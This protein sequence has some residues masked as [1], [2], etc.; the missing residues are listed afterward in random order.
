MC[1]LG[2][3]LLRRSW[4]NGYATE[5]SRALLEHVF[6]TVGQSRVIAQAIEGNAASR[7]V[8]ERLGMRYVRTFRSEEQTEVEYEMTREMWAAT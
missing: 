8:M 1:D 3:R 6:G 7:A 2:Y 4:G 5:A